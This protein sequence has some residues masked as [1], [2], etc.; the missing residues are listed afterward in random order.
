MAGGVSWELSAAARAAPVATWRE[1]ALAVVDEYAERT[2]GAY[3]EAEDSGVAFV[4]AAADPEFGMMMAKELHAH[5][6][7]SLVGHPVEM[8]LRPGRLSI[9]AKDVDKGGL[10][11]QVRRRRPAAETRAP[12]SAPP[13]SASATPSF[14]PPPRCSPP[15]V[16]ARRRSS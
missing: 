11:K 13:P 5:L 3:V 16:R 15:G 14:H 6:S 2:N 4:H 10:L 9:T 1:L 12:P 7:D 8:Q